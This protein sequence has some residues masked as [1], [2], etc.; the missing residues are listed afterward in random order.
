MRTDMSRYAEQAFDFI[1]RL[2]ALSSPD[3]IAEAIGLE[4]KKFGF[5]YVTCWSLPPPGGNPIDGVMLNT[6]PI[7]YVQHYVENDYVAKDPVITALRSH[8]R[9]YSWSDVRTRERLSAKQ[10]AIMDEA[11]DFNVTDGLIV[12]IITISGSLSLFSPCGWSP[13]LT[14]GSRLA[15]EMMGIY[16]HQAIKR[17]KLEKSRSAPNYQRLTAREREVLQWVAIGKSDDEIGQIL[18]ISSATVAYHVE[19]AKRKLDAFKRSLAVIVAI[20]RGELNI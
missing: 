20:Q 2:N 17:M 19:N 14:P 15:V 6:R 11:R 4:M 10:K 5:E 9:P 3:Q 13:D 1:D 12:P 16:T 8:T 7:E 18:S